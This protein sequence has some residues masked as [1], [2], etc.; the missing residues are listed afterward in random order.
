MGWWRQ[1]MFRSMDL[2]SGDSLLNPFANCAADRRFSAT[3]DQFPFA[4]QNGL[5]FPFLAGFTDPDFLV[6]FVRRLVFIFVHD[7]LAAFN[8]IPF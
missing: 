3:I 5:D 2:F 8:A 7:L 6:G 1:G 4:G